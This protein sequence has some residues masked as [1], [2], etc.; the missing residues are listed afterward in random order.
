[1]IETPHLADALESERF[2]QFLDRVPVAIAVSELEPSERIVYANL[3]FERITGQ[4][5]AEVVGRLWDS[6]PGDASGA[7]DSRAMGEAIAED[8]DYIGAFDI[9]L[10][11]RTVQVDAW[12]NVIED[13][14]G[15]P[16]FRLVALVEKSDRVEVD[17]VS[18]SNSSRPKILCC[19]SSSIA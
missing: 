19:V 8:R 3:E 15:V 7:E 16:M 17:K 12:S 4:T 11:G 14:D 1:M 9:E 13:D 10:D 5:N 2:K 6:L 18:S